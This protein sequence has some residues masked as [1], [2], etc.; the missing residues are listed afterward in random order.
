VGLGDR[1]VWAARVP[2]APRQRQASSGMRMEG[3]TG[4]SWRL[5]R[6]KASPIL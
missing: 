5:Y 2:A 4:P 1:L 3:S 6:Y